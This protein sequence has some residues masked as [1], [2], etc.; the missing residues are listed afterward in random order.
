MF[1]SLSSG[2]VELI[3]VIFSPP[4]S[5]SLYF[6]PPLC[7]TPPYPPNPPPPP[8]PPS[9]WL[10]WRRSSTHSKLGGL[11]ALIGREEKVKSAVKIF[12][13]VKVPQGV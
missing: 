13:R 3:D 1:V 11:A 4:P 12:K 9:L 2:H 10:S 5:L 6:L 8:S 7:P